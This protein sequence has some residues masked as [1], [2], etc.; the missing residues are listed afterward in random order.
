LRRPPPPF[1]FFVCAVVIL[2][3]KKFAPGHKSTTE[4]LP[5]RRAATIA[6]ER[7]DGVG[8]GPILCN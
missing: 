8:N 1:D 2:R 6:N 5:G 4:G 3:G 7:E